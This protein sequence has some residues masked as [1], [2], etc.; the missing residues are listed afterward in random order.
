MVREVTWKVRGRRLAGRVWGDDARVLA[1]SAP[2]V[3][4]LHGFLDHAG[5]WDEV[6][7]GLRS[8][9]GL[10]VAPDLR[11]HGRSDWNADGHAYAFAEYLADLDGLVM[12]L[13]GRVRLVGHSLGGTIASFYAG[14]RPERVE[15]CVLVDGI[16]I[17]DGADQTVERMRAF[18]DAASA[19]PEPR[20]FADISEA[21][22][23]LRSVHPYLT[24][25]RAMALAE[26]GTRAWKDG[27]HWAWDPR[28]RARNAV[29]YRTD[30]HAQV[31]GGL[32]DAPWVVVPER[33]PFR[34][35]AIT[36][37]TDALPAVHRVDLPACGHMVPLEA[38]RALLSVCLRAFAHR[39]DGRAPA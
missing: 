38:P 19:P 5:T 13:G 39:P 12:L 11:G 1:V 2:P 8:E 35:D 9:L 32:R 34:Q 24:E 36:R 29:P 7:P 16:G 17:E 28:L 22:R 37:L 4:L 3:V 10:V 18:L 33:S 21:A 25:E 15:G 27:V 14:L 6:A 20:R 26:R 30:V 23:R 31:L